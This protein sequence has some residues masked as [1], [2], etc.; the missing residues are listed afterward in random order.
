MSL[1]AD[2]IGFAAGVMIGTSLTASPPT[3][4]RFGILQDATLDFSADVKELY[5]QNRYAIA[6]APGK[7]KVSIKAKFASIRGAMFNDLYF[8]AASVPA[9]QTLFADSEAGVV[10][11]ASVYTVTVSNSATWL[12]D[13]GVYYALTGVPF[14]RVTSG[15]TSGQYSVA[16]GIYTFAV[17]DASV[18]VY[19]S[20]TYSSVSGLRI[21]I[22]NLAMGA[23]PAFSIILA[24][25][26][27]GRQVTYQFNNCQASKLS[28][29]TKQDDFTI[30]EMDFMVA[31]DV[32]GN[33]GFINTSL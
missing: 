23:G 30:A 33:I 7:T 29:P 13:Q 9:T 2:Q 25:P 21:P 16:A 20:Y 14:K 31:A 27:D 22:A 4:R 1:Y 32:S 10:P 17:A 26:F 19:I 15:P 11:G 3:P 8:G 6:L 5:G 12:T 28:L 24:Q 18:A